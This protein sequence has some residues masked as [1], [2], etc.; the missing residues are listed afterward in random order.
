MIRNE[1]L[2]GRREDPPAWVFTFPNAFYHLPGDLIG[3]IE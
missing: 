3:E 2:T 1:V